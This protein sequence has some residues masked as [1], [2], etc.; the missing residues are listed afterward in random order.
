MN[1]S[2]IIGT[3]SVAIAAVLFAWAYVQYRRPSPRRWTSRD[4]ISNTISLALVAAFAFGLAFL[5]RFAIAVGQDDLGLLPIGVA[6]AIVIASAAFIGA[7]R[8]QWRRINLEARRGSEGSA[9][10]LGTAGAA[11]NDP[12]PGL[13]PRTGTFG[14][15][16]RAPRRKAA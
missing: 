12:G 1:M 5:G 7:L 10:A 14:S 9:T 8:A 4:S 11:A 2:L 13:P 15:N 6:L 3:L 16:K